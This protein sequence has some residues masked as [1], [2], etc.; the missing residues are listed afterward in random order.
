MKGFTAFAEKEILEQWRSYKMLIL[1]A[2]LCL[3]G[4]TSPLLAKLTP[5]LLKNLSGP[6]VSMTLPKATETEAWRQFF[7][8]VGQM[9]IVV[10][11]LIYGTNMPQ[12]ISRGTIIIPL[13]KGL[14]RIAVLLAKFLTALFVWTVGYVL[15][16][17]ICCGYTQYLFGRFTVPHLFFALLCLWLFGAFLL[18]LTL[19]AG[20]S[21]PGNYGG[22]LLTAAIIGVLLTLDAFP[23]LQPWNPIALAA[24]SASL[25]TKPETAANLH[26][27]V[28][29]AMLGTLI[30]LSAGGY[31][32]NKRNL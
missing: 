30:C 24:Q 25:L 19:F 4:M 11:L 7:K 18:A 32:F 3:L 10:L 29:S 6:G 13:S 17:L 27:A 28:R 26:S 16:V 8:N 31:L 2:A 5:E 9:G 15:A 23:K 12:E 22:L 20:I 14:S 1:F 21:M